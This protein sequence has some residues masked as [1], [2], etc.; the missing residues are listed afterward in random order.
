MMGQCPY[1]PDGCTY[2]VHNNPAHPHRT[3]ET[4]KSVSL[5]VDTPGPVPSLRNAPATT[6]GV[7]TCP[8]YVCPE[9][10]ATHGSVTFGTDA[11]VTPVSSTV[12]PNVT[13]RGHRARVYATAAD[14]Q[15]A[16]RD[17]RRV[18]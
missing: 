5:T 4:L 11:I 17:R 18:G 9:C 14:R 16:Y 8:R 3:Q 15:R 1:Y 6:T 7:S 10:G 13:Q 12:T 2:R